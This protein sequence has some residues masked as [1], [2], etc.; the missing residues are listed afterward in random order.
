[1]LPGAVRLPPAWPRPDIRN[2]PAR[3][4]RIS[5]IPHMIDIA[6]IAMT[7]A[8]SRERCLPGRE[9]VDANEIWRRLFSAAP[10]ASRQASAISLRNLIQESPSEAQPAGPRFDL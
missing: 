7:M 4:A 6:T 8:I 10:A 3:A 9:T 5:Y 2:K 1:M